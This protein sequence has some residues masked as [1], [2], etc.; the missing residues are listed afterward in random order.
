MME[1]L[2]KTL[3]ALSKGNWDEVAKVMAK[4]GLKTFIYSKLPPEVIQNIERAEKLQKGANLI[5]KVVK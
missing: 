3:Q 2:E 4:S 5:E 1:G